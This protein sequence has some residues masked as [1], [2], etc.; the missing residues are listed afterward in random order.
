M[1]VYTISKNFYFPY[2]IFSNSLN[3]KK[4]LT[5][6]L[7]TYNGV[8]SFTDKCSQWMHVIAICAYDSLTPKPM[9]F[10]DWYSLNRSV[11]RELRITGLLYTETVIIIDI[12]VSFSREMIQSQPAARSTALWV[13]LV[14]R[15]NFDSHT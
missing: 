9:Q 14:N 8:A 12:I 5:L 4:D 1:S 15:E 2:Y 11:N 13:K 6:S 10:T 3:A 7:S